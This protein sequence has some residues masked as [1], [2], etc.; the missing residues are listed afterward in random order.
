M[1]LQIT[2][3]CNMFCKHCGM[4]ATKEGQDMSLRTFRKA[5]DFNIRYD[6]YIS[7][8]GGEPTIHPRFWQF[9]GEAIALSDG[10]WLAT[11]GSKTTIAL[12][13]AKMAQKGTISCDLSQDS[14]HAPID[15]KVVEAFS[16]HTHA[17]NDCR[18]IRNVDRNLIKSGRC[19]DGEEGCICEEILIKPDGTVKGCGC[20]DAII[21]GNVHTEVHI[22][23]EWQWGE[24]SIEQCKTM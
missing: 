3:K 22:P 14:F 12:A 11:N 5:I 21:L 19:T 16:N 24:C 8:G 13:L 17:P 20:I 15:P 6:S 9:L 10:V 4:N 18:N 1:Y 23:D 7:L 2:T